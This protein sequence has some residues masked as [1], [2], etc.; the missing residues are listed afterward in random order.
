MHRVR[1]GAT[2]AALV[3][4]S[5][6]AIAL[7]SPGGDRGRGEES[8]RWGERASATL[9]TAE[10]QTVGYVEFRQRRHWSRERTTVVRA[11]A[12]GLPPGFHGFHVH[13]VGSC[14]PPDFMSA[15]GHLN[16]GAA[17]HPAH[18]GD[19]PSLLVNQNGTGR[20]VA[21][22]DR[23][24]LEQLRDADG[25]AVIVHANPDNYANIPTS[26]YDP[27]PDATTL[28]TGDAGDRLACG[29]IR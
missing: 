22:T 2:L 6:G 18:A 14:V 27:D 24:T 23:F 8:D 10:G 4:V 26:R 29:R 12:W 3:L 19:L 5:A 11:E 21:E 15:G 17:T 25:S 1:I 7:A 9:V 20:L 13:A 28:A 16:P